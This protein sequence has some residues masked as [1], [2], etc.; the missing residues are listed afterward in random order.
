MLIRRTLLRF[1]RNLELLRKIHMYAATLGGLFLVLHVAYFISYPYS[2]AIVLG[3]AAAVVAAVVWVTGSAFLERFKDSLFY[4]GSLSLV[5]ISL[6]VIHSASAG[7]NIPVILAYLALGLTSLVVLA[8]ALG[9][10]I[11][12]AAQLAPA[13]NVSPV[14]KK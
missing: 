12:V 10:G 5:A 6:M 13:K 8:K 2:D 9:H 4:H 11:K 3:Y 1:S 7:S 14:R